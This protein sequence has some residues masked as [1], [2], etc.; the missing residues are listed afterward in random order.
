MKTNAQDTRDPTRTTNYIRNDTSIKVRI[1]IRKRTRTAA[2]RTKEMADI[3]NNSI[4][5]RR[6]NQ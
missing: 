3:R 4:I 2:C 5:K 6:Y 1:A